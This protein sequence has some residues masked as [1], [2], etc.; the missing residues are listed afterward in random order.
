MSR[1]GIA[2]MFEHGLTMLPSGVYETTRLSIGIY[3]VL[4]QTKCHQNRR[5]ILA[6]R[7]REWMGGTG[8]FCLQ[9]VAHKCC[10]I[11]TAEIYDIGTPKRHEKIPLH[12]IL[13]R[14]VT[15]RYFKLRYVTLRYVTSHR[16]VMY[17]I[18]RARAQRLNH[19]FIHYP[20]L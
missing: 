19:I 15:L 18:A 2:V 9:I 11:Y 12:H 10:C 4:P 14:Y 3:S 20:V 16:Y 7:P 8:N 17:D 5:G 6:R 13:L 1:K